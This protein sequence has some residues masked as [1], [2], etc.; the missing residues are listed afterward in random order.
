MGLGFIGWVAD[1]FGRLSAIVVCN[2]IGCVGG[3]AT[4]FA[5]NF[6]EFAICRFF[7]GMAYDNCMMIT[8]L[9]VLEYVAP[10][11]RTLISI[12]SFAIFYTLAAV[13]LPWIALACAHW[14][15]ICL[16]T[17]LPMVLAVLS[18]FILHE[19]PRWLLTRGRVDDVIKNLLTIGRINKK[20]VPPKAIEQFKN[21][22]TKTEEDQNGNMFEV[23]RR[24]VMLKLFL[25]NCLAHTC[26]DTAFDI[27]VRTLGVLKF[28]FF[29]SFTL[30]SAT[31]LPASLTAAF[32]LDP[33]GRRWMMLIMNILTGVFNLLTVF[34][35]NTSWCIVFAVFI[36]YCISVSYVATYQWGAELLPTPVR[37]TGMSLVHMSA[38]IGTMLTQYIVYLGV[39]IVWLPLA[40]SAVI[41]FVGAL[42]A[43]LLPE[44]ARKEMPQTFEDAEELYKGQS[45]TDVPWLPKRKKY[46]LNGLDNFGYQ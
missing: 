6:L 45:L 39:Y 17:S 21:S 29:L 30:V 14:K 10:K 27:S 41:C 19:S 20:T 37:G 16:A 3:V 42:V 1:R 11:H 44:T 4:I 35:D 40:I 25:L 24:P 9:L 43:F 46:V 31:E 32:F 23:F 12:S 8:F 28:D 26:C 7:L 22:V 38:F 18:P 33:I 36:R 15:T 13:A 2:T 5:T 34:V